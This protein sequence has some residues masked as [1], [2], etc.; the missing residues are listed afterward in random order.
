[1]LLQ[2]A[3]FHSFWWLS[4]IPL[5]VCVCVYIYTHTYTP[6]LVYPFI[7]WWTFRFFHV[8]AIANS[9]AMNIGVH[10]S[11]QIIALSIYMLRSVISGSYG[12][13]LFVFW[14]TSMLFSI[15]AAP[16]Y[17]FTNSVGGFPLLH[18]PSSICYL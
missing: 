9:A 6:H 1:M 12:N 13:S 17:I 14:G 15:V 3:L 2:M 10:V 16:I 18:T 5:C 11:F 8:L 7:C 4:N